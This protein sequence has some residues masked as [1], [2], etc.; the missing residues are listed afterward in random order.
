M[1]LH[2]KFAHVVVAA[3]ADPAGV[4]VRK[5]RPTSLKAL[6]IGINV[7]LFSFGKGSPPVFELVS[8]LYFPCHHDV[9]CLGSHNAR[10]LQPNTCRPAVTTEWCEARADGWQRPMLNHNTGP[11]LGEQHAPLPPSGSAERK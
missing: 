3:A 9:L 8:I 1:A 5:I 7:L 11:W 10:P 2:P 6:D 4:R